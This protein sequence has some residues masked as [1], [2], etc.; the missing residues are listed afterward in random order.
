MRPVVVSVFPRDP[1]VGE[2]DCTKSQVHEL[3]GSRDLKP[4]REQLPYAKDH[5]EGDEAYRQ[6]LR[7]FR[8]SWLDGFSCHLPT[9]A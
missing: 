3:P 7:Y 8:G 6:R 4:D 1:R 5:Q 9:P 2:R